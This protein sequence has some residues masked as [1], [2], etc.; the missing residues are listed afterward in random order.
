M[1]KNLNELM[2]EEY[3]LKMSVGRNLVKYFYNRPVNDSNG[4]EIYICLKSM[5]GMYYTN[6][7]K[8]SNNYS[9]KVKTNKIITQLEH[10]LKDT[11]LLNEAMK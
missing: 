7:Y 3:E 2:E 10:K 5:Y 8:E 4:K 1:N 9:I 6:T 11:N